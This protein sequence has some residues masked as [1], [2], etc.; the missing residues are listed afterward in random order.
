MQVSTVRLD[1]SDTD[2]GQD[3]STSFKRLQAEKIAADKILQEFTPLQ[4]VQEVES[5]RDYLQNMSMKT[6]VGRNSR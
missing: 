2:D 6:E 3:V 1:M 5:L 4:S